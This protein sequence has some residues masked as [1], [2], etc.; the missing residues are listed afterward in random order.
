MNQYIEGLLDLFRHLAGHACGCGKRKIK[1]DNPRL[2]RVGKERTTTEPQAGRQTAYRR[3]CLLR[4]DVCQHV[5][6]ARVEAHVRDD[7]VIDQK[8]R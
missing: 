2:A 5:Q 6:E 7:L 1:A 3:S 4:C 8:N